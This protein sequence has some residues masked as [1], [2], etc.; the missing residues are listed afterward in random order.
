MI[1][2]RYDNG[3]GFYYLDR[4]PA[5]VAYSP[6]V[7]FGANADITFVSTTQ[8]R[9]TVVNRPDAPQKATLR[10]ENAYGSNGM[11]FDPEQPGAVLHVFSGSSTDLPLNVVANSGE[12]SI[13]IIENQFQTGFR[14][15]ILNIESNTGSISMEATKYDSGPMTVNVFR[16]AGTLSYEIDKRSSTAGT[17]NLYVY[18]NTGTLSIDATPSVGTLSFNVYATSQTG[19]ISIQTNEYI[20]PLVFNVHAN[21]AALF[22]N[23]VRRSD[24]RAM[25]NI[26]SNTAQSRSKTRSVGHPIAAIHSMCWETPANLRSTISLTKVLASTD[27]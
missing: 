27:T 15:P 13:E 11:A 24:S 16:N 8:F 21:A 23:T 4:F 18:A 6:T 20:G 5:S 19:A 9:E 17:F 14:T 1:L 26:Y 3:N 7:F 25:F 12:L 2:G 22:F 10:F